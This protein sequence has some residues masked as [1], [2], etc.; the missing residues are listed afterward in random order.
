MIDVS[1]TG[2]KANTEYKV[3]IMGSSPGKKGKYSSWFGVTTASAGEYN[4]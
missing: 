3:R 1:Y 2:L 4:Q